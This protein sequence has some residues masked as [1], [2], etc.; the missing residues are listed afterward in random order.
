[1]SSL[2]PH[3]AAD[4]R[5]LTREA[6][7]HYTKAQAAF[8]TILNDA[9]IQPRAALLYAGLLF[10]TCVWLAIAVTQRMCNRKHNS[11]H[12]NLEKRSSVKAPDRHFGGNIDLAFFCYTLNTISPVHHLSHPSHAHLLSIVT[13]SHIQ[14]RFKFK[15]RFMSPA[16][17][18][19]S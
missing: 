12:Q 15:S 6:R 7:H 13:L 10:V 1:M 3:L 18:H 4:V 8:K 17:P 5:H 14:P 9:G 11:A 16:F 19:T 2:A